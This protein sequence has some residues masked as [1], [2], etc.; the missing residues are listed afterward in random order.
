MNTIA[1]SLF[2]LRMRVA[3]IAAVALAAGALASPAGA[4]DY[5]QTNLVSNVPG[6]A[7]ITDPLL[8]NPWGISR[9]PTSPFWTSNQSTN[10]ATLYAVT[11]STNVSQVLTV[12]ANGFVAIPTTAAGP[13]GPTGQVNNTNTSSFQLTPGTA[14][15]SSRFIFADL[16]GTI[17]GWAGGNSSTIEVTTPGAVYTGL[18]INNAGTQLYAANNAGGTINVFNSSFAPISVPG[19]FTDPTLPAGFVPFNVQNI[20][21]NIYV[22][23]APAGVAAQRA[24]TPGTGIVNIFNENGVLLQRLITGSRL[25]SPWGVALAPA[26]FGVLGGSLLV[27]NFSFADSEINAFDPVTGALRGSIA[28]NPGAGNTPG[29]LW[30]LMFGSGAG[31]GG[32]V[33]TLYFLDGINGETGGLFG[34]ITAVPEPANV[35]MLALGLAFLG[36]VARKKSQP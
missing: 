11:G 34:A 5:D 29:G 33:N 13:Q 2:N 17:S 18:A 26:S 4:A 32:D 16:N 27:G 8:V 23:Y 19:S 10:T 1:L 20:G 36:F 24:A 9:S 25:A 14:S 15:T 30:A 21:G 35:T 12:N 31:T 28:I 6:L 22:T 3:Q 7:T